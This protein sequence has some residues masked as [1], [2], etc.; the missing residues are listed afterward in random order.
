MANR[1]PNAKIICIEPDT[2]NFDLLKQNVSPYE[3]IFCENCGL[4]NKTT[5]LKVYDK[6]NAGKWGIITEEDVENG[7]ISAISPDFLIEKYD[8]SKIDILKIDIET[9][10]KQLFSENYKT[11]LSATKT[12]IIE[13][14]DRLESGCFKVFIDAVNDVFSE[15][16]YSVSGENTIIYNT[17]LQK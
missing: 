12:L 6:F 13:F 3:N 5:T 4:W 10:E 15:Y 16:D 2:E 11:W 9:S 1:F 8:I 17:K 7:T 14:H